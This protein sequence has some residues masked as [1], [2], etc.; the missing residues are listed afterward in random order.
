MA[1]FGERLPDLVRPGELSAKHAFLSGKC[2]SACTACHATNAV[3]LAR[4][5]TAFHSTIQSC[6]ACHVEHQNAVRLTRMDHDALIAI[7]RSRGLVQAGRPADA[8]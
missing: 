8:Q 2:A 5:S 4:Q 7:G 3:T 1:G 6:A